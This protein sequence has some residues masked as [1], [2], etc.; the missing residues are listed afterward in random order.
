M[1]FRAPDHFFSLE[2]FNVNDVISMQ[3]ARQAV[4]IDRH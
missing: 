3:N 2:Y 1:F 4:V